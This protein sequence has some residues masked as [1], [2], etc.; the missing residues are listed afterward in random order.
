MDDQTL[1]DYGMR[2]HEADSELALDMIVKEI[3]ESPAGVERK[4]L[5]AAARAKKMGRYS[6]YPMARSRQMCQ[7]AAMWCRLNKSKR[8]KYESFLEGEISLEQVDTG[9]P[10][11]KF[12]DALVAFAGSDSPS[13]LIITLFRVREATEQCL[14]KNSAVAQ[15]SPDWA[16]TTIWPLDA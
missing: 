3:L 13:P 11:Q 9:K 7:L 16:M 6:V 1:M 8:K 14:A 15:W 2:I 4:M 10:V 12:H 5:V